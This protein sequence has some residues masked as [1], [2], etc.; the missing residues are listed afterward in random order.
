VW[1]QNDEN[2]YL[3]YS[4]FLSSV[5]DI[6]AVEVDLKPTIIRY[7]IESE[8]PDQEKDFVV[9]KTTLFGYMGKIDHK[10]GLLIL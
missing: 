4:F 10:F 9:K 1:I 2:I 5:Y 8:I 3:Y 6:S 7:G